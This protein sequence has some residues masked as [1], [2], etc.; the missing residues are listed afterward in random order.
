MRRV[1]S[2][3]NEPNV[4]PMI[5][6][7]LVLLIIFMLATVAMARK[8]LDLVL[9]ESSSSGAG[10]P[11]IVLSIQAGPRYTLN[12]Q[13]IAPALLSET[14]RNVFAPRPE[15]ILYVN[16]QRSLRYQAVVDVFDAVR[17][18]GIEVTAI[19]PPSI[20]TGDR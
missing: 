3:V 12:G 13:S 11:P 2:M 14:L 5:D 4:V 8:S 19:A 15:K 17:G 20:R 9:P 10:E 18:S 6:V 16:A 1:V 7:L